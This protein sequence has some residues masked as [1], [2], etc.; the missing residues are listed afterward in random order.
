L[1]DIIKNKHWDEKE[2]KALEKFVEVEKK[3]RLYLSKVKD[4]DYE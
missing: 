2:I 3:K 1:G 4:I